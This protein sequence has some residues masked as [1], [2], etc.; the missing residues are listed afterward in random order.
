[1][2]RMAGGGS[3]MKRR[4]AVVNALAGEISVQSKKELT[5]ARL[6]CIRTLLLSL[7][8][9]GTAA[10]SAEPILRQVGANPD[11]F[12]AVSEVWPKIVPGKPL[13]PP[14]PDMDEAK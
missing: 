6:A 5:P 9:L 12:Q 10:A 8:Q 11:L 7:G 1:M 2:V 14:T 13:T 4:P 3:D